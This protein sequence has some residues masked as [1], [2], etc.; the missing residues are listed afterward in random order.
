GLVPGDVRDLLLQPL[1]KIG[2]VE[3]ACLRVGY[4]AL[5]V[6]AVLDADGEEAHELVYVHPLEL[7]IGRADDLASQQGE[8]E[9]SSYSAHRE[10]DLGIEAEEPFVAAAPCR[11][12]LVGDGVGRSEEVLLDPRVARQGQALFARLEVDV[13]ILRQDLA[14][15]R[16]DQNREVGG[17]ELLQYPGDDEVQHL[18]DGVQREQRGR[19][20]YQRIE[21]AILAAKQREIVESSAPLEV[22]E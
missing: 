7:R 5:V 18:L 14:A 6:E 17:Y 3:E 22:I 12:V 13:A 11:D 2:V 15:R 9:G 21:E 1:G 20:V 19:V 10:E 8:A 16:L 4:R